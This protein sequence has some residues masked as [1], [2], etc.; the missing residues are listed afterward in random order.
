MEG[1]GSG[2]VSQIRTTEPTEGEAVQ[3]VGNAKPFGNWVDGLGSLSEGQARPPHFEQYAEALM[4][5]GLGN[6][7][8]ANAEAGDPQTQQTTPQT[9]QA[10][11]AKCSRW[12][13]IPAVCTVGGGLIS[14]AAAAAS[15]SL[16]GFDVMQNTTIRYPNLS[17]D[18]GIGAVSG[19]LLGASIGVAIVKVCRG[20]C[21]IL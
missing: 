21:T 7:P 6:H 16:G 3:T 19:A 1:V 20:Q 8:P 2:G 13:A 5:V 11:P 4:N 14:A 17:R 12:Y 18:A 10:A 9:Q 15:T